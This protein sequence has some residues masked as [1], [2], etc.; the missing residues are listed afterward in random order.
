MSRSGALGLAEGVGFEPTI[1]FP[2]YTRSRRAPSTTRPPLRSAP[3]TEAGGRMQGP[4]RARGSAMRV[5]R[6][7][8][9]G[10]L[11][12][13]PRQATV[14]PLASPGTAL[15]SPRPGTSPLPLRAARPAPAGAAARQAR[16]DALRRGSVRLDRA[17]GARPER[18]RAGRGRTALGR[19]FAGSAPSTHAKGPALRRVRPDATVDTAGELRHRRSV[20][21]RPAPNP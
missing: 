15:S 19:C 11:R 10:R 20:S 2:V 3:D 1:R 14:S 17:V 13:S 7:H 8:G 18:G 12:C 4:V 6:R 16:S 5:A 9:P 21:R